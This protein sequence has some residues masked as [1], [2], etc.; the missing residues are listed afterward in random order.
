MQRLGVF[1]VPKL[2]TGFILPPELSDTFTVSWISYTL[3]T[4]DNCHMEW[5]QFSEVDLN[6]PQIVSKSQNL[7]PFTYIPEFSIR[8]NNFPD[9]TW[10]TIQLAKI[11]KKNWTLKLPII[12]PNIESFEKLTRNVALNIGFPFYYCNWLRINV[13]SQLVE[14]TTNFF[15]HFNS[16]RPKNGKRM[17]IMLLHPN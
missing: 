15:L 5:V 14:K 10:Q 17:N 8:R 16:K 9:I 13:L 1:G 2:P 4:F 11:S 3:A 6:V 12:V 7:L